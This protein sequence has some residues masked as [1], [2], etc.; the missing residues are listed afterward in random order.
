MAQ[1]TWQTP[2]GSLGVIREGVFY[3]F[4]LTAT[5]PPYPTPSICYTTTAGTNIITCDT[6]ESIAVDRLITFTG[7]AFGGIQP[8]IPYAIYSIDGPT[9]FRIK[10]TLSSTEPLTLTTATGVLTGTV[11]D[12]VFYKLQA[13]RTPEGIQ[14]DV[15]GTCYGVPTA[16]ADIQGVPTQVGQDVTSK[17]TIR[18]YSV[19]ESGGIDRFID[20]TFSLTVTGN[21][22]ARWV[23]PSGLIGTYIDSDFVDIQLDYTGQD[24]GDN[25]VVRLV[26]GELPLGLSLTPLGRIFGY[27]RPTADITQTPGYDLEPYMTDPYDFL[28]GFIDRNYQ[29]TLEVNDGKST[30][31]RT[32]DIYVY[33]RNDISADDTYITS[34]NT[35]ITADST[36]TRSPFLLNADPSDLGTVRM[37]NNFAYRFVG[38]DYDLNDLEYVF[39]VNQGYG[40][41]PGLEL[42]PFSGWYYGYI[43]ETGD[44]DITYSFNIQVRVRSLVIY[45]TTAGS[46]IITCDSNARGDFYVGGTVTFDGAVI[47]GL[48]ENTTYYV[49]A[50][51]SDTE[52]TVSYTMGGPNVTLSTATASELLR[53]VPSYSPRS[54][55]YPFTLSVTSIA[56][57][58]VTWI[59]PADL[60]VIENGSVSIL[61]IQAESPSGLTLSYELADGDYNSLPQG[62]KLL[63]TGE[64]VG[65]VS[66]QTFS[67]DLGATTIDASTSTLIRRDATTIDATH[68]FTVNAYAEEG[69]T[70][71]Y[72]VSQVLVLDGGT[73]FVTEPSITFSTPVGATAVQAMATVM[74]D[75]DA[76]TSVV[77]TENGAGYTGVATYNLSGPGTGANLQVVM[78]QN[79]YR[80][81]V[82]AYKTF[83]VRV[84]RVNNKPY[85]NLLITAMPPQNDRELLAQLLTD[86][87]IFIPEYIYRPDDPNFGLSTQVK[88]QHAFGLSPDTLDTYVESL[89]L[90]HYWKNLVL[91]QIETAR[92]L[93]AQGNTIY[94]VV[95][96]RVVDNLV[97]AAGE[98]V[99]KIVTTPYAINNP[100]PPPELINSVYPNSL[101]NMR[102]QVIDVV[103]QISQK[104]PLWMTSR[105]SDGS[106]LGF[107]PAWVIC[108]TKPG[109]SNQIAYYINEYFGSQLNVI[110]FKVDRY[111]LDATLSVNWDPAVQNWEPQP[112]ETTFDGQNTTGY[113]NLGLVNACTQLAFEQVN[114]RTID[115]INAAG[116]LDGASWI[117]E[118]GPAPVGTKV[119]IRDGSKIIFVKQENFGDALTVNQAFTQNINVYD[120]AGYDLGLISGAS[121][122]YDFGQV[123]PGGYVSSCTSTNATT[124]LIACD[125]TLAMQVNDRMWFN[126]TT[127]GNISATNSNSQTQVY[128]VQ[129]IANVT[130]TATNSVTSRIS[131]SSVSGMAID[132]EIWFAPS[133]SK[134]ITA[135]SSSGNTIVIGDNGQI[136]VNMKFI[137]FQDI[138]NLT[139]GTVYYI[140]TL[141]DDD[142]VTVSTTVGGSA[143]DPGTSTGNV[144]VQIGGPT[145]GLD[146]TDYSGIAIPYYIT[147]ITGSEIEI[148]TEPGGAAVSMTTDTGYFIIYTARF[149]VSTQVNS[150]TPMPLDT[151]TGIMTANYGNPRMAIWTVAI[152]DDYRVLLSLD[153]ET[154]ANDYVVSNQGQRY[155]AGTYLYR[156]Q[157]PQGGLTRVNWQPFILVNPTSV[158]TTFDQDSVQW[159]EPIDMYDPTDRND[160]YLVFPKADILQ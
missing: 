82:S 26:S 21:D 145:G 50:I 151:A 117:T 140:K 94:E 147:Y 134:S 57:H 116:G 87:Q 34:D 63:P 102:E 55:E 73:G 20:R 95:Y 138:G 22:P 8:N 83:T 47:G 3:Q 99:S 132:D 15:N 48:L 32:F 119:I 123:L 27:V 39:S 77:V 104:L 160:K 78:Q 46:D 146:A 97:N 127:Y 72:E 36:N 30:D 76:I 159:V 62:L 121:G 23:T 40:A 109:R 61:D 110:D 4:A 91:G 128:Y 11:S 130:G 53:C 148:S 108:Y 90:N 43:P 54:R 37:D 60:G 33:N 86:T 150:A 66:F 143:V 29:F 88:Y 139:S 100:E 69:Q 131:V 58:E 59:T 136:S 13:G 115:E 125:S 38:Q 5:L 155:P 101:I 84:V 93:D 64:I 103:G 28:G 154:V 89:N 105:Q 92:A 157:D 68:T 80:R 12:P 25:L 114:G 19:T 141:V 67:L 158:P 70:P 65:R 85:Q 106:V 56:G 79:G 126:G 9:Q 118:L 149:S 137:P 120:D 122:S 111:T 44:T 71:L 6:T 17:F 74:S 45:G 144:L 24:P 152:S 51:I 14:I 112:V 10:E 1:P 7:D 18:A 133:L 16:S 75:G 142:K 31:Q 98:S 81:L 107:T 2:A 135:T 35:N 96:S 124:D 153:Q 129:S 49:T 52:F 42:D 156:P 41:P 113:T